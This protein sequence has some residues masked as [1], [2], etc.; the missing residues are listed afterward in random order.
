MWFLK[1][2]VIF[3]QIGLQNKAWS[4]ICGL[5]MSS[6]QPLGCVALGANLVCVAWGFVW[7]CSALR[8]IQCCNNFSIIFFPERWSYMLQCCRAG[9]LGVLC[10][11][12]EK[13]RHCT[14]F[15]TDTEN[16][17]TYYSNAS[18][19]RGWKIEFVTE[20]SSNHKYRLED[21]GCLRIWYFCCEDFGCSW[22]LPY[23]PSNVKIW[24]SNTS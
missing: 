2:D 19:L 7:C 13:Y 22:W 20:S 8:H 5:K 11:F 24:T 6:E 21:Q 4:V 1:L 18:V 17:L 15:T 14:L 9:L 23:T 3:V 16:N 10:P 12:S